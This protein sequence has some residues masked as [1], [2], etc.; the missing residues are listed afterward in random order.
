MK[1]YPIEEYKDD[2]HAVIVQAPTKTQQLH[3]I[4]S[5][6]KMVMEAA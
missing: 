6:I 4:S 3:N 5:R 2:K 1:A